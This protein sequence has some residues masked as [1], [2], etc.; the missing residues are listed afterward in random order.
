LHPV[1]FFLA[2][3]LEAHNRLAAEVF[4]YSNNT[5]IDHVTE[6]LRAAADD[7]LTIAGLSDGEACALIARDRIDILVDLSG[8]TG[9]NRLPLFALRPAPV[10]ISWLG[11]PGTTGLPAID[12]LIMDKYAVSPGEE[13]YYTEAVVRL[14]HGR[15]CYSPPDYAPLP[16]DPPSLRRGF[17][18]FGSF[19]NVS[20]IGP[21]VIELWAAVLQAIPNSRLLFKW[22]SLDDAATRRRFS[23]A[24]ISAGVP[25]HQIEFQG[26]VHRHSESIAQY[27]EVDIALDP[28]PFSGCTTTC[29]SFWMGIPVVTFPGEK[30]AS[31][32]VLGSF[33]YLGLGDCIARS[34]QDYVERASALAS[35][36]ARLTS[37][38]HSLRERMAASP[39]CDGT[40]FAAALECA[41]EIM[42]GRWCCGQNPVPFDVPQNHALA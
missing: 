4:C 7:W 35:N 11:Y 34:A 9:R 5:K 6:R 26:S 13:S 41:Y 1:G 20:K 38:R 32:H 42:W 21:E 10:Q 15:C 37:L 22:R 24:F 30:S 40:R 16:V 8:H 18:T 19:N 14:P 2:P 31:R 23:N 39:L 12:Y 27:G 33:D 36:P 29:E 28:F 3:V 25:P 17:V